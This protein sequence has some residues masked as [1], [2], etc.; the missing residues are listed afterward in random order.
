MV[1]TVL[2]WNPKKV[3]NAIN[4]ASGKSEAQLDMEVAKLSD[5]INSAESEVMFDAIDR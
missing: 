5:S 2:G 4:L 3:T 1:G